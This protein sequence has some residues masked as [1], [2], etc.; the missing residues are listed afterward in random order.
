MFTPQEAREAIVEDLAAACAKIEAFLV[1]RANSE[2]D[3][4]AWGHV[5]QEAGLSEWARREF[6]RALVVGG[7][8]LPVLREL[9]Q[10]YR[11]RGELT[12]ALTVF[13]RAL[14]IDPIDRVALS[15]YVEL[16]RELGHEDKAK[17]AL[18]KARERGGDGGSG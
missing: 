16:C 1:D 17:A 9:G 6:E 2:R 10:L 13:G 3:H 12:R 7:P 15:G 11:E 8:S 4:V 18:A 5:C 14:S